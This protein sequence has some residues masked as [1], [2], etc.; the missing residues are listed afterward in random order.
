MITGDFDV[1][2]SSDLLAYK[3]ESTAQQNAGSFDATKNVLQNS[4]LSEAMVEST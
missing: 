3:G 1:E 2:G 4:D